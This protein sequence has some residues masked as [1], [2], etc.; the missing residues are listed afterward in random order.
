[1]HVAAPARA[2]AAAPEEEHDEDAEQQRRELRALQVMEQRFPLAA[3]DVSQRGDHGDPDGSA[4]EVV[5]REDAP[6]HPQD[7]GEGPGDDAHAE[8]EAREED[9]GRAVTREGLLAAL[10]GAHTDAKELAVA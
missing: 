7:A 2:S 8:Q 9:G 3:E 4:Q 10:D 6:R 5:K 1:M